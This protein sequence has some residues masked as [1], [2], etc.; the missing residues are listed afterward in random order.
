MT[1]VHR[2]AFLTIGHSPRADIVPEMVAEILG[3]DPAV[4]LEV[5]EFGVLDGLTAN[6]LEAMKPV[7][8]EPVFAT[9][10]AEGCE[11]AVSV[12]RTE[13]RLDALLRRIDGQ[14]FDLIVL[15]CTGTRISPPENTLVIEAQKVVDRA[16]DALTLGDAPLGILLPFE[17]QI[18]TLPGR[19]GFP[20]ETRLAAASPYDGAA[21]APRATALADCP[22]TVMHCMGYTRAMR[23]EL[24]SALPNHVLHAR[25]LVAGFARQF[26]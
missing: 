2:I 7:A 22:V 24:R 15:L 17:S 11:M 25:G 8:D 3:D 12:E 18:A 1:S 5:H 26:L 4:S 14:N 23:D 21:L 16:I 10:T 20:A 13:A 19:H 6:E 9:R